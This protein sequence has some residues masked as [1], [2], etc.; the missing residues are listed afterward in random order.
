MNM[1]NAEHLEHMRGGQ[2]P[3]AAQRWFLWPIFL[4][5]M[6]LH[7]RMPEGFGRDLSAINIVIGLVGW[8]IVLAVFGWTLATVYNR[9]EPTA[10]ARE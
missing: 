10:G 4:L 7:M 3:R 2:P 9:L 1:S 5:L 6:L 8:Y